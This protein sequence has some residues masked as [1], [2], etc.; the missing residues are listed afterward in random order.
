MKDLLEYIE[1]KRNEGSDSVEVQNIPEG[2]VPH[3]LKMGY[4]VKLISNSNWVKIYW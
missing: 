1:W 2:Y 4:R 3:L